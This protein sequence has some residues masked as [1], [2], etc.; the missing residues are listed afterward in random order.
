M[1]F[2]LSEEFLS[3]NLLSAICNKSLIESWFKSVRFFTVDVKINKLRHIWS[4]EEAIDNH[5]LLKTINE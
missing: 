1:Y 3:L 4:T 5:T 2:S